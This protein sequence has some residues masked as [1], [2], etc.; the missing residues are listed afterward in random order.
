MK[1]GLAVSTATYDFG[2]R[3]IQIA[4]EETR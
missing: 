4:I 1:T 2:R 3:S